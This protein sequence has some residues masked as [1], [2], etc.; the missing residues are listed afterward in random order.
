MTTELR[1]IRLKYLAISTKAMRPRKSYRAAST[2]LKL[3]KYSLLLLFNSAEYM[4]EVTSQTMLHQDSAAH[5]MGE[6]CSVKIIRTETPMRISLCHED[7]WAQH[8]CLVNT[9]HVLLK[10]LSVWETPPNHIRQQLEHLESAT[11]VGQLGLRSEV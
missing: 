9:S 7:P 8:A 3:G 6:G 1:N 4:Q 2:I 10:C 5:C 11:Q